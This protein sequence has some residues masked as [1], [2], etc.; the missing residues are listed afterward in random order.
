MTDSHDPH[1]SVDDLDA[2]LAGVLTAEREDHL[3]E[4]LA[5]REL[6][7]AERA[8]ADQLAALPL[9]SPR[10]DFPDRVMASVRI[11]DPFAIHSLETARRRLLS[12]RKSVAIASILAVVLLGSMTASVVWT[13]ANR[14]LLVGAGNWLATAAAQWAW[15]G[16]RGAT[17]AVMEQP[18]YG[19]L[20]RL[21]DA[22]AR[23]ALA[24]GLASLLYV[25]GLLTLRR[26]LAVPQRVPHASW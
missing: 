8:L 5:C 26:L 9:L 20:R 2:W 24:M 12:S 13:L 17:L 10:A 7:R 3:G 21:F 22:P 16:L 4:C 14:D 19:G 1:L 6:A 15:A 23:L 11:P 25:S 18:W